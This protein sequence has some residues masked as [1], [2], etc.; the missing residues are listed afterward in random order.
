MV[1]RSAPR[2]VQPPPVRRQARFQPLRQV[3]L[4]ALQQPLERERPP[5]VQRQAWLQPRELVLLR[6]QLRLLGLGRLQ[7]LQRLP[8][9]R[10]KPRQVRQ[11]VRFRL[12]GREG[13]QLA[14]LLVLREL[15]PQLVLPPFRRQVLRP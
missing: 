4:Q 12:L 1:P 15:L 2:L 8:L 9:E 3:R 11:Q 5:P 13:P 7:A 6:F 10:L 14:R